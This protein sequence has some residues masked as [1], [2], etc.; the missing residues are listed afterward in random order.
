MSERLKTILDDLNELPELGQFASIIESIRDA[1]DVDHISYYAIS[2]GIDAREHEDPS[3]TLLPDVDGVMIQTGR[4]LG[5]MSFSPSWLR[6]YMEARHF[7]TDPVLLCASASFDPID[8]ADLDWDG[9]DLTQFRCGA[10]DLGV[11]N[12]GYTIPVRGPGGQLALFTI[13]KTCSEDTWRK[14]LLEHR[15]D[16]MLLAHFTHQRF[17]K[18]AGMEQAQ[19]CRP[20]SNRE[21]DVMRL[22]AD[23]MSRGRASEMLGISENTFR[24]YIDSARHKLGALNIPHAIALAAHR[25]I[26]PPT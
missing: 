13:N 20:L 11:G 19:H 3:I 22:I 7:E 18:L 25:G 15:T 17:L 10:E 6:W 14:C 5:A 12:Q 1:Y 8:W 23:G 24:V 9:R 26:I 2:L 4:K 16:F 21:R